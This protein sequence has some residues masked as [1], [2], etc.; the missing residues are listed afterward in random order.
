MSEIAI[1][2]QRIAKQYN[3]CVFALSQVSSDEKGKIA[4]RG[5]QELASAADIVLWID[6]EQ[7]IRT[8]NLIVRKNRPFGQTGKIAFQFDETWTG[9]RE[10]IYSIA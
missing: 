6:R 5:A 9:I 7:D 2:L 1:K 8:F 3:V 10:A 4:L